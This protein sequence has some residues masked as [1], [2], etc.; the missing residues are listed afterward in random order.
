MVMYGA[1]PEQ[2]THLGTTLNRQIDAIASVMSS[3]DGVLD[4]TTWQ[5]PARER[6]VEE[7]NGSFKQALNNLNEAFGM[8]GRDC[9][10]RADELRRVM[11]VG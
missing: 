7:W 2:L 10:A 11:G 6:F 8:A 5:G 9:V 4:G 1:N 3:V